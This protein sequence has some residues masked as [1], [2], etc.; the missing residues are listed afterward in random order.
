ML[1]AQAERMFGDCETHILQENGIRTGDTF[2][3]EITFSPHGPQITLS[4]T[5]PKDLTPQQLE[6][7]H[8]EFADL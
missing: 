7:L 6:N 1:S 4:P 3:I 5:P 8:K 2:K